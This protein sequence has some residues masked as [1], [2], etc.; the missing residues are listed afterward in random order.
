[1]SSP[2]VAGWVIGWVGLRGR[3]RVGAPKISE[4]TEESVDAKPAN[5]RWPLS[6]PAEFFAVRCKC[7][8]KSFSDLRVWGEEAMPGLDVT[9]R[10]DNLVLLG[11]GPDYLLLETS[12]ASIDRFLSHL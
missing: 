1:M 10:S 5:Q 12:T 9:Q 2:T 4:G 6:A 11:T 8:Q 7:A 3:R